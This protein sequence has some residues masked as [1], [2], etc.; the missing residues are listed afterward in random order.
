MRILIVVLNLFILA[1][2]ALLA[3][4]AP[5]RFSMGFVGLMEAIVFAG[6]VAGI[7]PVIRYARGFKTGLESIREARETKDRS[8]WAVL[9]QEGAVFSHR[10]LDRLMESYAE[11]VEMQRQSGQVIS[12]VEDFLNGEILGL[13]SWQGVVRQIPGTLGGI[14]VLGTFIGLLTGLKK[15]SLGSAGEALVGAQALLAGIRVSFYAAVAGVILSLTFNILERLAWNVMLRSMGLFM[16]EFHKSV[17][18]PVEEQMRYRERRTLRQI[19]EALERLSTSGQMPMNG[20]QGP[21]SKG[22]D[23]GN[24]QILMPQILQ[25]LKNGEFI[26]YLQPRFDLNTRKMV[27]AEA[28]VRWS[29]GKLGMISP[30]V[31]IP[32]LEGNGYITKLDQYI[33]EQVCVTIRKWVDQGLRPVPVSINVTKTDVLALDVAEFFSDMIK[34]Y[35]IPPNY[36]HIEIAETA[37]QQAGHAVVETEDKLR[38][39][40]FRVV[41]DGFDGDFIAFNAIEDNRADTIK[42]DLRRLGNKVNQGSLNMIFDQ[43]KNLHLNLSAEGIEN[44]NQ[45]NILRQCGCTEGQGFYLS[46]PISTREFEDIIS[47]GSG[48]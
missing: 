15:V 43:A 32:I 42:L 13:R 3:V 25:G 29:H 41:M 38:H 8:A 23:N 10:T 46:K 30:A 27:G 40:G 12:D 35:R 47:K 18:P 19:T 48:K 28:L 33:W 39:L 45:M 11:K 44:V 21:A 34:K 1:G 37:Y 16:D 5:D 20:A 6:S 26:F 2:G 22:Q 14:G 36:L 24:E 9:S 31:F 17:I 4:L 7:L